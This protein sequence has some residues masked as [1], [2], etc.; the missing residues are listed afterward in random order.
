MDHYWQNTESILSEEFSWPRGPSF[1][2]Y[3]D[4]HVTRRNT[5]LESAKWIR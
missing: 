1:S 5:N 3:L 2:Q 4:D